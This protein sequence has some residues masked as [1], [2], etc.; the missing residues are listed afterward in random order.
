MEDAM[1]SLRPEH[2]SNTVLLSLFWRVASDKLKS[3][4]DRHGITS[5][6]GAAA[7]INMICRDGANTIATLSRGMKGV[8]YEVIV[9]DVAKAMKVP[10]ESKSTVS[11][12][13]MAILEEVIN[14]YLKK[15]TPE[16][17]EEIAK[18]LTDVEDETWKK[19]IKE[20]IRNGA[21]KAGVLIALIKLIGKKAMIESVKKI[22]LKIS[23]MIAAKQIGKQV[24]KK[25]AQ[26]TVGYLIPFINVILAAD[27]VR[28]IAGPAFR[29]TIPTVIEVALLRLEYEE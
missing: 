9:R 13:E 19:G 18:L 7:L 2:E 14:R 12:M 4:Y 20:Q 29:K 11:S 8:P 23:A 22:I 28:D 10:R 5:E 27:T 15:A 26:R 3:I 25:A 17:R 16:E 21:I 1:S 24:A 6:E